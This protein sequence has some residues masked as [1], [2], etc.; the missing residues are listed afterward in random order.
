MKKTTSF[1][2]N[3]DTRIWCEYC[4]IFVYN[5]RINRD[6]HDNSPQHQTNFKKRVEV[7]R[8]EED[9]KKILQS[10][11]NDKASSS[12]SFYSASTGSSTSFNTSQPLNMLNLKSSSSKTTEKKSVL[13]LSDSTKI[14]TAASSNN[15]VQND[16][17]SHYEEAESKNL[18]LS[19]EEIKSFSSELKRK[20]KDDERSVMER[21]EKESLES[22]QVDDALVLLELLKNMKK[23]KT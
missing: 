19:G 2:A 16:K 9:E 21:S 23:R 8:R 3:E 17:I 5:N 1:K 11:L 6:K 22:A 15:T 4:R 14:T 7:L 10:N 13:G 20:I 12:K 18:N